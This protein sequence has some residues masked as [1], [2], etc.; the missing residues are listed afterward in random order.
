MPFEETEPR[1]VVL[2]VEDSPSERFLLRMLL[3]GEGYDTIEAANGSD[4]VRLFSESPPSIVLVDCMMPVMDGFETCR[5]IRALPEGQSIPIVMVTGLFDDESIEK[6]YAAGATEYVVKPYRQ[7]I[8]RR[9]VAWLIRQYRAEREVQRKN[10]EIREANAKLQELDRLKADF[11]AMLV[12]DLRAP[13]TSVR[14]ALDLMYRAPERLTSIQRD[15]LYEAAN[16][17]LKRVLDLLN[18]VLD[19]YRSEPYNINLDFVPVKPAELLR[20]C[21]EE[22]RLFADTKAIKIDFAAWGAL[23]VMSVDP[24]EMERVFANLLSNAV[25][26]TEPGGRIEVRAEVLDGTGVETGKTSLA[27]HVTDTGSGIPAALLPYLFDPYR[28]ASDNDRKRGGVGLGLAIVKRIVAAHGGN[29][30]VHSTVGVGSSFT[31]A[32]PVAS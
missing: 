15:E 25:K 8:L 10:A 14:G 13:L 2:I 18:D 3:H 12:H 9:R 26:F 17:S 22:A 19:L 31:V 6:G 5:R 1:P 11:T 4:A 24:G 32:L 27:V 7:S 20:K 21:V 28:Q 29:V 16:Q 30:S 23:P